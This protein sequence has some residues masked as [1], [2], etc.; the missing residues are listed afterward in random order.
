MDFRRSKFTVVHTRARKLGG[1]PRLTPTAAERKE[2][3]AGYGRGGHG[4]PLMPKRPEGGDGATS[5]QESRGKQPRLDTMH[6]GASSA[7]LADE[8]GPPDAR[9]NVAAVGGRGIDKK[10][11]TAPDRLQKCG[12]MVNGVHHPIG[13]F[14]PHCLRPPDPDK[15][16]RGPPRPDRV[17]TPISAEFWQGKAYEIT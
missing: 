1:V 9:A 14:L 7:D 15:G 12:I 6:S 16:E 11:E 3:K 10:K 8:A 4:R 13:H 5:A 2:K 17:S